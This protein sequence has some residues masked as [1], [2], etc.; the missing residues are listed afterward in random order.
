MMMVEPHVPT[1]FLVTVIISITM[2]LLLAAGGSRS[3]MDGLLPWS[4]TLAL[5]TLAFVLFGLRGDAKNITLMLL[6][7]SSLSASW[8][9]FAEGLFQFQLRRPPRILI[10]LPVLLTVIVFSLFRED[11]ALRISLSSAIYCGQNLLVL[12]VLFRCVTVS[13]GIATLA[14]NRYQDVGSLLGAADAA[15]YLAKQSGRNQVQAAPGFAA[16]DDLEM[17]TQGGFV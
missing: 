15:L 16:H 3:N 13:V 10:W 14:G 2:T 12:T 6:A 8:A 11:A 5:H 9:M 7:V 17:H 4:L 1:V